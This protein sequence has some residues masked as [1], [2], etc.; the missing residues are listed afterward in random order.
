MSER[1][2]GRSS[3]K[4]NYASFGAGN[5]DD[6]FDEDFKD[7]TPPPAK[8]A[9][10]LKT[11]NK[12]N[13][14]KKQAIKNN[15]KG[16]SK[17][18]KPPNERTF[19][20]ELQ[21]ALEI[22]IH[23]SQDSTGGVDEPPPPTIEASE[24]F[25]ITANM[26]AMEELNKLKVEATPPVL[27]PITTDQPEVVV[28]E[29]EEHERVT[30]AESETPK[31]QVFDDSIE[32]ISSV[33]EVEPKTKRRATAKKPV[34]DSDSESAFDPDD[35]DKDLSDESDEDYEEDNDSDFE[36]FGKKKK[37]KGKSQKPTAKKQTTPKSTSTAKSKT[38]AAPVSKSVAP[39]SKVT[40]IRKAVSPSVGQTMSSP[41]GRGLGGGTP[42]WT[43][44]GSGVCKKLFYL[45]KH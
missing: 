21:L 37:G 8:K 12:E 15:E 42:K 32:V 14:L 13:T 34:V 30:T 18:R 38:K 17:K 19:D 33:P 36:G 7:I 10:T 28:L 39:R 16:N 9:K 25:S 31:G 41:V 29:E 5:D 20:R 22:S 6:D 4:V 35:D 23:E 11:S 40:A 1:K 26:E 43:P 24:P 44:P 2:S 3:K 45:L 27:Q